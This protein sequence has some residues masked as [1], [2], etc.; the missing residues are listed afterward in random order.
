MVIKDGLNK[1]QLMMVLAAILMLCLGCGSDDESIVDPETPGEP[2]TSTGEPD[3]VTVTGSLKGAVE[4]IEGVA[5]AIRVLQNGNA[6]ASTTADADGN[7]QIDNIAPGTYTVE[8][9]AKGYETVEQTVQISEDKVASLDRA[10]LKVLAIPVAHI[11]GILSDQKSGNPLNKVPVRLVDPAGNSREV[12]TTQT[13]A[14]EFENVPTDQRFTVI[15]DLEG[16][17]QQEVSIDPI[18]AG[19]TVPLEVALVARPGIRGLVLDQITKTPLIDVRV[20]LT[21]EVGNVLEMPTTTS[22]V[23]E[24]KGVAA[25]QK[26]TISIDSD[27]YE[28]Q[29]FT[30]DPIP[31]GETVKLQ[32]EL[33]PL[34]P[35]QLPEGDGLIVGAKAPGFNLSD[36]DGEVIALADY[37]GKKKVVLVF[38]RG[39]W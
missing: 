6:I 25:N 36:S 18:P 37:A 28:K 12:L 9:A 31:V 8:I 32:V 26:L 22:G 23:F 21:D 10:T 29:E 27:K 34:N 35:D 4:R 39:Q 16:F 13:G 38:D 11:Q 19:E 3:P 24:F 1:I 17:E 30:V 15:V 5:V 33:I 7:Y 2:D 14:F 20:Q